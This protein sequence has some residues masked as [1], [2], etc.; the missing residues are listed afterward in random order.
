MPE[1]L[2]HFR[3]RLCVVVV[4]CA[5]YDDLGF[6]FQSGLDAL[7]DRLEE[8]V[9]DYFDTGACEEVAGEL[10]TGTGARKQRAEEAAAQMALQTLHK[11]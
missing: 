10:G 8:R 11:A 3:S 7:F 9:V 5:D 1:R 2:F 6:R 4:R